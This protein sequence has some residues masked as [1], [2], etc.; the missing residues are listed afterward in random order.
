M[1]YKSLG[2]VLSRHCAFCQGDIIYLSL[3]YVDLI[4]P[5]SRATF[6]SKE[7]SRA[8]CFAP[9]PIAHEMGK[10]FGGDFLSF[11]LPSPLGKVSFGKNACVFAERRMRS[12]PSKVKDAVLFQLTNT[13]F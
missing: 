8:R 5:A 4:R 2:R 10:A 1:N 6:P 7:E 13:T 11:L 3:L 12:P 9:G